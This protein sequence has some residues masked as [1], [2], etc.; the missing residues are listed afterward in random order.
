[1]VMC[2]NVKMQEGE[3]EAMNTK[4]RINESNE[5]A[6]SNHQVEQDKIQMMNE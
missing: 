5:E 4:N 3:S 1:M 2:S 6:S